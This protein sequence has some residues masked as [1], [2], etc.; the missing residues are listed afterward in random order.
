MPSG[1]TDFTRGLYALLE[2]QPPSSGLA[3][4]LAHLASHSENVPGLLA[5]SRSGALVLDRWWWSTMAYGWYGGNVPAAGLSEA[6]FRELIE[7]IWAPITAS[8]VFLFL[9]PRKDD[10]NNVD[11]V[12][13]GYRQLA[14]RHAGEVVLVPVMPPAETHEF[15]VAALEDR[16]LIDGS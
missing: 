14:E 9:T 8:A 11:G 3:R 6:A 4:Q 7:C 15:I 1:L 12:S 5:A 10:P 13:E 16:D 2:S